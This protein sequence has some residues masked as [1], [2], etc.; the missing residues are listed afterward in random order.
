MSIYL[1]PAHCIGLQDN[2]YILFY[3]VQLWISAKRSGL[4][5]GVYFWPGSEVPGEY[6]VTSHFTWFRAYSYTMCKTLRNNVNVTP[7]RNLMSSKINA[8][9]KQSV[10]HKFVYI[11]FNLFRA[12]AHS[13]NWPDFTEKAYIIY[14]YLFERQLYPHHF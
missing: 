11:Y 7:S 8:L 5:S 6:H 1:A 3:Y 12:R 4:T 10:L 9:A 14:V 13:T 2:V